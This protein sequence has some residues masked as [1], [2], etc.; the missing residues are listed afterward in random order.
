VATLSAGR[1]LEGIARNEDNFSLQLL[2][3]DGTLHLLN[4]SSLANLTYREQSP[5][6]ADYG[7]KLSSAELDDLVNFLFSLAEEKSSRSTKDDREED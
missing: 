2:T 7:T 6:P 5:M 1:T 4:K 3:P